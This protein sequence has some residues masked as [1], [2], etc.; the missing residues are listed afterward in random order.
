MSGYTCATQ[1]LKLYQTKLP[2]CILQPFKNHFCLLFLFLVCSSTITSSSKIKSLRMNNVR[3]TKVFGL[4]CIRSTTRNRFCLVVPIRSIPPNGKD[5]I[6][7]MPVSVQSSAMYQLQIDDIKD[8][9]NANVTHK[10]KTIRVSYWII[11]QYSI[12]F[13]FYF[14]LRL[15]ISLHYV[16]STLFSFNKYKLISENY[17]A[18]NFH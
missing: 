9:C 15:K 17:V 5:F 2:C 16:F 14:N 11:S 7:N 4:L 6:Y 13:S 1:K 3:A 8:I 18:Y 10:T 12:S